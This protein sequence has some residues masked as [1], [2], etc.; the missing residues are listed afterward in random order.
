MTRN[1][2]QVGIFPLVLRGVMEFI[3]IMNIALH[4][5]FP[6]NTSKIYPRLPILKIIRSPFISE[7][8][9]PRLPSLATDA[10]EV[11]RNHRIPT[12]LGHVERRALFTLTA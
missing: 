4:S 12:H 1:S 9:V 3:I 11:F 5:F 7:R 8:P 6:K 2:P 10:L